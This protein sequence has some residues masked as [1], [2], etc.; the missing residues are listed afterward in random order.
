MG[1]VLYRQFPFSFDRFTVFVLLTLSGFFTGL[2]LYLSLK[3]YKSYTVPATIVTLLFFV[4]FGYFRATAY[5]AL[6]LSSHYS[7]V[8]EPTTFVGTLLDLPTQGKSIKCNVEITACGPNLD[9]M[10]HASGILLTYVESDSDS[11]L[12]KPGDQIAF[13][14]KIRTLRENANPRVFDYGQYLINRNIHYQGFVKKGEWQQIGSRG[15]TWFWQLSAELR[16]SSLSVINRHIS[17]LDNKAVLSAMLLGIRSMISDELYDAYTDTGAVHVLAVSG[18]HVGI[19]SLILHWLFGFIPSDRRII[20][21]AKLIVTLLV[22][23][24]FVGVTGAAPAVTRA[25]LMCSFLFVGHAID[26][27]ANSYNML[28]LS[29][30]VMLL[31]NPYMLYQASF[32]F[33]FLALL[34]ILFF[35]PILIG[36]YSSGSWLLQKVVSLFYVSFAAQVLVMPLTIFF[37]HK[38]ATYFWLSGLFVVP[39][40]FFI[41]ALGL[42]L[43]FADFLSHS[44]PIFDILNT[45]VIAP[46]LEWIIWTNNWLVSIVQ[47]LPNSAIDGLWLSKIEVAI[48]YTGII[49]CMVALSKRKSWLFLFGLMWFVGFTVNRIRVNKKRSKSRIVYI[50]DVYGKSLVDIIEGNK[51]YTYPE[52][53]G[54]E[55][56]KD[57]F[58]TSNNRA[59]HAASLHSGLPEQVDTKGAFLSLKDKLL[60]FAGHDS[61]YQYQSTIPVDYVIIKDNYI[62]DLYKMREYFDIRNVI[63]DGSNRYDTKQAIRKQCYHLR[64]QYQDTQYGAIE[65][66]Y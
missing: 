42:A 21:Y 61:I 26:K 44:F 8:D 30:L 4:A 58:I 49:T 33:S 12:L 3:D 54:S 19:F 62:G 2:L 6:S 38:V 20:K 63:V 29:A 40:A 13:S 46:L 39:A 5:N 48:L 64:L 14:V 66:N 34:S 17:T 18:L 31:W 51:V 53:D 65:I 45:D 36:Y 59:Y 24:T 35:M 16:S 10:R 50:Y 22:I 28:C 60:L 7:Y 25:A 27:Q 52:T 55:K 15:L 57:A 1:I 56:L 23:W 32:Q 41:L 11:Q 47:S 37:F 9:S 43:L